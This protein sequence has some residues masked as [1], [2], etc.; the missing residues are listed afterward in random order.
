MSNAADSLVVRS[1][2]DWKS[3]FLDI[4]GIKE[5]AS[6]FMNVCQWFEILKVVILG[7]TVNK[8]CT[9]NVTG[10]DVKNIAVML[11]FTAFYA[12]VGENPQVM[13]ASK[14]TASSALFAV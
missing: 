8:G 1:D 5:Q 14:L 13:A 7:R 10:E 2:L 11:H 6:L 3:P 12:A 4:I 9:L